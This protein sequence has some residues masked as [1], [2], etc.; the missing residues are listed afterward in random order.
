VLVPATMILILLSTPII[1]ALYGNKWPYAPEF[2]S[3]TVLINLFAC[4]G[5]NV[6]SPFF[7]ALGETKLMLKSNIIYLV[8][9]LPI[10]MILIPWAGITGMIIVPILAGIPQLFIYLYMAKRK[11]GSKVNYISSAKIFLSSL[12]SAVITYFFINILSFSYWLQLA[13]GLIGFLVLYLCFISLFGALNKD[14]IAN[15][16]TIFGGFGLVS[17]ILGIPL[18]LIEKL[19]KIRMMVW[20]RL[21]KQ[22]DS[23]PKKEK[24]D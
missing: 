15:L 8:T 4:L 12:L 2:L 17:K 14:E 11:F 18:G 7:S 5:S 10:A 16:K 21:K 20:S 23:S 24:T 1:G 6:A 13:I 3:Y 22:T 19:I 9:G